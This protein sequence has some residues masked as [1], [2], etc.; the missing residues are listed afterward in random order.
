[1]VRR[2]AILVL[3]LCAGGATQEKRAGPVDRIA[4][5]LEQDGRK[6]TDLAIKDKEILRVH[7]RAKEFFPQQEPHLLPAVRAALDRPLEVSALAQRTAAKAA[8]ADDLTLA[9]QEIEVY[10]R[11]AVL[12][13]GWGKPATLAGLEALDRDVAAAVNAIHGGLLLA[14][15]HLE[16]AFSKLD[17]EDRAHLRRTLPR[18]IGRTRPEDRERMEKGEEDVEE[19]QALQRCAE[20]WTKVD[21]RELRMGWVALVALVT[22]NLAA[23]RK[24][25]ELNEPLRLES[26]A[27]PV[28]LRGHGNDGGNVDA[29]LVIDF[30]GD[31]EY[32]LPADAEARPVRILLDLGGDD[33]Y[34][35]QAP[36]AWGAA[37]LGVSLHIDL[38]GD[39][40]YRARDWSLGCALGGHAALWD[41]AG[42]DRYYGG[43]GAQGVGIFGTGVLKDDA[44]DDEY[45][46]GCFCQG[47]GS[48][49]G[50][51]ALLDRAGNDSYLAGR[52]EEDVWRRPGTYV[53]FAQGSGY[54]HRF[55][56]VWTDET[57]KRRWKVTGQIPGGVG[58]LF[59][60]RGNDRYEADVFGQG[61][62]YWYSL[63]LLVDGDGNDRYRATWYGQGVGTHAAVGCLVDVAGD[64]WYFSRNTSQGCGHDFSAGILH[65]LAGDDTY[66]GV[67]L[68]QG[69]GNAFSGLGVLVDEAGDDGYKCWSRCWGFGSPEPRAAPYGFFL[70]LGGKNRYEGGAA[71]T[72]KR[73][74]RWR[75][76]ERGYGVD[77][78]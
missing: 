53:T 61:S 22:S 65:D 25:E 17:A 23:L 18:W 14:V 39:D 70:D 45:A 12:A 24:Q 51:G 19:R 3:L 13:G 71:G 41:R 74:G 9:L 63:G 73:G 15:R 28:L 34:L 20:L 48:T 59:D 43:L 68:C 75:Q 21:R 30:G 69:A 72:V 58:L 54:S 40:D 44:G 62:A 11:Q 47:F 37:L 50:L 32:R 26:P 31:D 10:H 46:A 7:E 52:D 2:L 49:A 77:G 67:T 76:G 64:D 55:G 16:Q 1:M 4:A 29:V 35:A 36:F 56:H 78:R 57:G 27:G 38:G 8:A 60:A 6:P 42:R 5:L 66:R 33:L